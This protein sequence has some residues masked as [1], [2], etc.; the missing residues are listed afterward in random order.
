[1]EPTN[2]DAVHNHEG[3]PE[4]SPDSGASPGFPASSLQ[5]A[6]AYHESESRHS[7]AH[8]CPTG[9]LPRHRGCRD[10]GF[11]GKSAYSRRSGSCAL[12]HCQDRSEV[13]ADHRSEMSPV[14]RLPCPV[15]EDDARVG[16]WASRASRDVQGPQDRH[17]HTPSVGHVDASAFTA[18][19]FVRRPSKPAFFFSRSR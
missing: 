14:H 1:M 2:P 17:F 11:L 8:K 10:A 5:V 19:A 9:R 6:S 4:T 18:A 15:I 7:I 3:D 13:S 16:M 12:L